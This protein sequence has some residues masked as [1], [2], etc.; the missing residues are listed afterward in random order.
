MRTE[1][2][3]QDDASGA[4]QGALAP[5]KIQ[6]H[7]IAVAI[8]NSIRLGGSLLITW[9]VALIVKLQVPAHLGPIRQGHFGFAESFAAI[10]F[11][12]LSLG[13]ETYVIKEVSVRSKHASD[14]VGGVFALRV[15]MS[16]LCGAAMAMTLRATG[17]SNEILLASMVFGATQ[18]LINVNATLA[19]VLQAVTHV[20]R[21]AVAN[22][23]AK[24][25]WGAG[26]LVGLHYGVALYA[27][28]LPMLASELLRTAVLV[29]VAR[30]AAD[31]RYRIDLSALRM[32]LVVSFPYFVNSMA[33]GFGSNL[34]VSALE[35]LRRDEREVGWFAASMNL[36]SLAMLLHP[37]IA[38]VVMPMLSRA[39]ARSS[40]EMTLIVRRSVEGLIVIIAPITT[41]ISVG[42][43]IFLKV[44]FGEKYLPATTGL[45]I[46]SLT[47]VMTY[48][49][50]ILASALIIQGK[51]WTVTLTSLGSIV[52][53][54][55]FMA[56]FVPA[57]RSLFGTGGE[58][59][60][61]A[62]AVIASEAC[63]VL[64][65]LRSTRY[66]ALD[67]RN[68]A[69]LVK[70]I[71]VSIVV[72]FSDRMLRPIGPVRLVLDLALYTALA[73]AAG[74]VRPADVRRTIRAL[75]LQ[76]AAPDA[77][78]ISSQ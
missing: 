57:G 62:V 14:F 30:S 54:G 65:M 41:I 48:M 19:A 6:A 61:A 33:I 72:I 69:V 43:A 1:D 35:Y 71:S 5:A 53:L 58:C 26:L 42:S 49:N 66:V 20:G 51:S 22:I 68:V 74:I 59:A 78:P 31:L 52:V 29:P 63:V 46:L 45:S 8:R 11:S 28:A 36:G 70:S 77:P 75:R 7:E 47:F 55:V 32:V 4:G 10:F 23:A 21:L 25:I 9:S 56:L 27:L 60:G 12:G 17:R 44:A 76:R 3:V 64:A 24:I 15:L 16:V 73:L 37:L 13:V 50:I 67:R 39:H 34:G 38:W 18:L 2:R 40:E